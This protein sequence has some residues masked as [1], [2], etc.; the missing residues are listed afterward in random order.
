MENN[1]QP[2]QRKPINEVL[3]QYKEMKENGTLPSPES[4]KSIPL[5]GDAPVE[6]VHNMGNYND[7]G[8]PISQQNP[9][10]QYDEPMPIQPQAVSAQIPTP[11]NTPKFNKDDY[12]SAMSK[13][14]DPDLMTS[15]EMVRIPSGGLYGANG[16]SEIMIEYM[17]S[18]DEDLLTTPSLIENG[19]VLDILLKRKVK[20]KGINIDNLLTGDR[21]AIILFLRSSSYGSKYTVQVPDPRTNVLFQ[22]D[23]DL[24]KLKYKK[25]N[26][27]PDAEG[28][29][30]VDIPMRK[31]SVKLRLLTAGEE[32]NL[33]KQA[34]AHM[35]AFNQEYSEVQTLKLKSHVVSIDG[36]SDRSYISK[37][38]DAMPA[39][40]SLT[41]RKKILEVSPDIDMNYQFTAKDGYQFEAH[42]SIGMDFFF[43][44]T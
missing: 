11:P 44:S 20:T 39:L 14:T 15:Y 42:L 17:T 7:I 2:P 6:G 30:T 1:Q 8:K 27:T 16:H 31:K 40:D 38:I 34:Q 37:F 41:I 21:N 43:P 32:T 28:C 29:F 35:E 5:E 26:D 18:K 10:S 12:Q 9:I 22:T 33:E 25:V 4:V 24:L 13:E 19:T 23:V 3:Q 36:N